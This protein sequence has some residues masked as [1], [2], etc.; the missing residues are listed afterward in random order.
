LAVHL[1]DRLVDVEITTRDLENLDLRIDDARRLGVA[2]VDATEG[3]TRKL[4]FLVV[5]VGPTRNIHE[6]HDAQDIAVL[7]EHLDDARADYVPGV[8]CCGFKEWQ[9]RLTLLRS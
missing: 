2:L 8:E 1:E 7:R 9:H 4:P 3:N 5:V 6:G